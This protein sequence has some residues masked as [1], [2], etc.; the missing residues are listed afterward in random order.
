MNLF[1]NPVMLDSSGGPG[2]SPTAHALAVEIE[3]IL[4]HQFET[5]TLRPVQILLRELKAI[6]DECSEPS[7]DGEGAAAVS[8]RTYE[9]AIRF[10]SCLPH[11]YPIPEVT[12]GVQGQ[13][14][15]EWYLGKSRSLIVSVRGNGKL[16][17]SALLPLGARMSGSE[18]FTIGCPQSI[19]DALARL[20]RETDRGAARE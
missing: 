1:P 7:W 5:W 6:R 11:R 17:Y 18:P 15:F 19:E 9:E 20:Y 8:V 14:G 13:L 16:T 4:Q 10:V 3:G 12:P 2:H